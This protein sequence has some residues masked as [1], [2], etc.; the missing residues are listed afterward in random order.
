[1]QNLE[2]YLADLKSTRKS[3]IETVEKSL[4]D[5][6]IRLVRIYPCLVV[7]HLTDRYGMNVRFLAISLFL[8]VWRETYLMYVRYSNC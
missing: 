8:M 1:M 4:T 5:M 6:F 7:Q 2:R 3:T